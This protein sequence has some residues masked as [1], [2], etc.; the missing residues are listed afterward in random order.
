[1]LVGVAGP[2]LQ[3]ALDQGVELGVGEPVATPVVL[4]VLGDIDE[5]ALPRRVVHQGHE[6]HQRVVRERGE[7]LDHELGAHLASHVQVVIGSQQALG[8]GGTDRLDERARI[9]RP[10]PGVH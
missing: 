10:L 5:L 1:M 3:P 6:P 8:P 7:V 9:P 4:A 2:L